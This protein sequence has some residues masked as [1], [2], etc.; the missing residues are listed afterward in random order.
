MRWDAQ[1]IDV[2]DGSALPGM[3]TMRGLLRSIE[4]P[5]CPGVTLHEVRARSALNAVPAGSAM[6]F[7]FTINPYRGC[8]HAC[9]YCLAGDTRVLMADGRER[10][11]ATLEAGDR[12]MGPGRRGAYRHFVT[13]EV[14]AHWRTV[15]PAYR[16]TLA[17]GTE[18]V[19]SGDHRLLSR[20]G[21]KHVSG[22]MSGAGR[23]PYLTTN[24]EL[25]GIGRTAP[26]PI[27]CD[28]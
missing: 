26:P 2:D 20:R 22:A 25:L 19:A 18:L 24:D 16:I 5:E 27:A 6:P 15:K 12:V 28:K 14:S 10:T 21:W 11:L 3:P 17:D 23:R 8:L 1:R 9:V 4:A 7:S 13:T